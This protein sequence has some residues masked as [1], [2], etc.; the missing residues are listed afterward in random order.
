MCYCWNHFLCKTCSAIIPTYFF[1]KID[2]KH[3]KIWVSTFAPNHIFCSRH[4][5]CFVIWVGYQRLNCIIWMLVSSC[6][7]KILMLSRN[8][9]YFNKTEYGLSINRKTSLKRMLTCIF[10]VNKILPFL[11]QQYDIIISRRPKQIQDDIVF[12]KRCSLPRMLY[13]DAVPVSV[14]EIT[15]EKIFS[16][17]FLCL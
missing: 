17:I 4:F 16:I 14:L 12:M 15:L 3:Q 2:S 5:L 6:W 11:E 13:A 9:F 1:W 10:F 7:A 8:S